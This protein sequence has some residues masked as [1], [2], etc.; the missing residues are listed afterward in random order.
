MPAVEGPWDANGAA[1]YDPVA[2]RWDD[3]PAIPAMHR[4]ASAVVLGDGSVLVVGIAG[5]EDLEV[6]T[7]IRFVPGG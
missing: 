7:A 4:A 5:G 3:L 1:A 6:P 2:D